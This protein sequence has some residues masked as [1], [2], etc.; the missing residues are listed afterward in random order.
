V[1]FSNVSQQPDLNLVNNDQIERANYFL[2]NMV[3]TARRGEEVTGRTVS[4]LLAEPII[5]MA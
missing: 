3:L 4:F 1:Y 5:G 2:H